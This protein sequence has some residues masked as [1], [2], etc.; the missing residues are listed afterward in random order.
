MKIASIKNWKFNSM[1]SKALLLVNIIQWIYTNLPTF[2]S[3]WRYDCY[4]MLKPILWI[5]TFPIGVVL[6]IQSLHK[7]CTFSWDNLFWYFPEKMSQVTSFKCLTPSISKG[8][9]ICLALG[10]LA[11]ILFISA[12]LHVWCVCLLSCFHAYSISFF[13]LNQHESYN[14]SICFLLFSN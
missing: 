3:K 6:W 12:G 2:H 9:H 10:T 5:S 8:I 11:G 4:S 7:P 14:V 1:T 13:T